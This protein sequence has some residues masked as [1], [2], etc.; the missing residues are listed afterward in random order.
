MCSVR[1]KLSSKIMTTTT[2]PR[3]RC[4]LVLGATGATGSHV[5]QIL[6][7][8]GWYVRTITRK[9][10]SSPVQDGIV[11][12][13]DLS[14]AL[15]SLP[16]QTFNAVDV[17]FNCI[18]T[19]RTLAGSAEKFV[20][21][22]HKISAQAANRF[23]SAGGKQISIISAGSA[24]INVPAV[25]F[26][27]PFLYSHTLGEKEKTGEQF[28]RASIFRPGMLNRLTQQQHSG[29]WVSVI[30]YLP[31]SQL[32]VDVLAQAMVLDAE[33]RLAAGDKDGMKRYTGNDLIQAMA[34]MS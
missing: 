29:F 6:L 27:H 2:T 11:V 3:R 17:L 22:E 1:L 23:R 24:N 32:R 5:V 30:Q 33:K 8:R 13:D 25:S 10:I 20:E 19:T 4:A 9:P 21:I 28:D 12:G 15:T 7:Q 14:A 31:I 18:G 26:F 16:D 34:E